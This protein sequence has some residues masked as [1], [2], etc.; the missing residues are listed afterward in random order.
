[1]KKIGVIAGTTIDTKMGVEFLEKNGFE[2]YGYPISKNCYEQDKMQ[3]LSREEL[4][5]IVCDK[6]YHMKNNGLNSCFVY[7]NSLSSAINFNKISQKTEFKIITPYDAYRI[8]GNDYDFLILLA[9]NSMSTKNIEE[10]IKNINPKIKF[11]S[12]GFL[13][14]V[15]K[16]ETCNNKKDI[17]QQSGIPEMIKFFEKVEPEIK[18]KSLILACTHFPHIKDEIEKLTNLKVIDPAETMIELL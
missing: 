5:N 4:E 2:A 8:I 18:S 11:L 16:I 15:N 9:A 12:L 10:F 14:L 1:M 17:L 6:I 13:T 7:C 3:Y